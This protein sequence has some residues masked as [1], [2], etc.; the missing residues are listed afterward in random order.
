[1]NKKVIYTV[2]FLSLICLL[3]F[4]LPVLAAGDI[5]IPNPLEKSGVNDFKGLLLKIAGGVGALIATLGTIMIIVAGI[6]YLTSAGSPEKMGTAKK[7]LIYAIAGITIG[8]AAEAIVA[9]IE[10]IIGAK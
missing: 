7:A 5:K 2:V 3:C 1:M 6:L 8:L 9:I 4:V 10:G